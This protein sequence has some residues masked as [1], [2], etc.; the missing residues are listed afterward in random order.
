MPTSSPS[1]AFETARLLAARGQ[2]AQASEVLD[3]LLEREPA[4]VSA[5]L[6]KG[7]L[8]LEARDG[9][10][11]LSFYERARLAAPESAEAWNGLAR[12]LH[13]LGRDEAA[14][15]A[16]QHARSL[17]GAGDN[18]RHAASVYLTLVWC[19]REMR[20][21]QEALDLATEGLERCP[22]AIL[23]QWASLVEEELAESQKEEC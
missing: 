16:A 7:Q 3:R 1:I 19:L 5:L 14:L 15:A 21:Y 17:L 22:D 9:E 6:L 12:C 13:A 10:D 4:H 18:F 2:A 20:H 11:A 8:Q 23:A